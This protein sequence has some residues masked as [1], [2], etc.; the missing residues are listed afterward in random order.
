MR[1]SKRDE[2]CAGGIV[3][4]SIDGVEHIGVVTR[5]RY[6]GDCALPKGHVE[7]GES[8]L[9][10]AVREVAEE[11]GAACQ[12][13]HFAGSTTYP[14]AGR[15]KYVLFWHMR[16]SG[17][18]PRR[19]DGEEVESR[20]WLRVEEALARLT[21]DTDRTLLRSALTSGRSE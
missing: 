9:D 19:Q 13:T 11:L 6:G 16:Y 14:V 20:L 4:R 1:L 18:D 2:L 12:P 15:Q 8:I 21:Y 10:A 3:W 5:T 17:D 7:S